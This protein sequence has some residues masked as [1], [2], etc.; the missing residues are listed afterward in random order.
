MPDNFTT[1]LDDLARAAEHSPRLA[2]VAQVRRRGDIRTRNGRVT[3]GV[4]GVA[5]VGLVVAGSVVGLRY[6]GA[7]HPTPATSTT[8]TVP[9]PAPSIEPSTSPS[10]AP[11]TTPSLSPSTPAVATPAKLFAMITG[12]PPSATLAVGGD[13]LQFTATITNGTNT[14]A[15]QIAPVL[16]LGTCDCSNPDTGLAP[17]GQMQALDPATGGWQDIPF[18]REGTGADF[19]FV[20]QVP[21]ANLA[22]GAT[23]SVTYRIRINAQQTAPIHAGTGSIDVSVVTHP[24]PTAQAVSDQAI[25]HIQYTTG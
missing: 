16:S 12:L 17:L 22:P 23:R 4:L 8:T 7:N 24:G 25:A 9:S 15:S 5:A 10:A 1:L 14:T 21:A 2:P 20:A 13:W 11:S 18:D 19:M 3:T 6:S